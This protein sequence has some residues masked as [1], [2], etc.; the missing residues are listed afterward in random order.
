MVVHNNYKQYKANNTK[1]LYEIWLNKGNKIY[2]LITFVK[3]ECQA[4]FELL[5]SWWTHM[6]IFY[7]EVV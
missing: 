6:K 5:K 4:L 2:M 1:E 7:Q 3:I